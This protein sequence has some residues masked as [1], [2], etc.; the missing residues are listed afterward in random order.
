MF[1][2]LRK[3]LKQGAGAELYFNSVSMEKSEI[4]GKHPH[5]KECK[6][7]VQGHRTCAHR[8]QNLPLKSL[9]RKE[10]KGHILGWPK[11]S[12]FFPYNVL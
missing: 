4:L 3:I 5:G 7:M 2:D 8:T 10:G 9:L 6:G 11:S 12:G 1:G